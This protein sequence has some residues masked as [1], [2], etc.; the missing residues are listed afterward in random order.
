VLGASEQHAD[1]SNEMIAEKAPSE[2]HDLKTTDVAKKIEKF[3]KKS[4]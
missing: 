3:R 4:S 1:Q 2:K